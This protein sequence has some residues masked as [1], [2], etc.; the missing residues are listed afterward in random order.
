MSDKESP[1]SARKGVD[2]SLA[3]AASMYDPLGSGNNPY[4]PYLPQILK[5]LDRAGINPSTINPL[6]GIG[7]FAAA[8]NSLSRGSGP[9]SRQQVGTSAASWLDA[10]QMQQQQ[11]RT[12]DLRAEADRLYEE[13]KNSG[14]YEALVEGINSLPPSM[15]ADTLNR[16]K[17]QVISRARQDETAKQRRVAATLGLRGAGAAGGMGAMLAEMAAAEADAQ[18]SGDIT[19]LEMK[20]AELARSDELERMT[21][22]E[23]ALLAKN[24]TSARYLAMQ[25]NID[26]GYA[27]DVGAPFRDWAAFGASLD[28]QRQSSDFARKSL[29]GGLGGAVITGTGES[30]KG[31]FT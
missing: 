25:S 7:D 22:L 31:W 4:Q 26:Q 13:W 16:L 19:S 23:Q 8:M 1:G 2:W 24:D 5:Q 9:L 27:M 12:D 11:K 15:G 17:G 20:S 28:A 29:Y 21:M 30:S 6:T 14:E 10:V 3:Y 18:I